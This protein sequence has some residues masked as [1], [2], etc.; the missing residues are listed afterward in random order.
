MQLPQILLLQSQ[1]MCIRLFPLFISPF[2]H[3]QHTCLPS[4]IISPQHMH[5]SS[6]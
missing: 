1:L 5:L 4:G 3:V 2:S 6:I